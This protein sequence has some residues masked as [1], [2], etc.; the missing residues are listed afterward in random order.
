MTKEERL[1]AI[2]A[3]RPSGPGDAASEKQVRDAMRKAFACAGT[4]QE[5]CC[6]DEDQ[7][8]HC[9]RYEGHQGMCMCE[10]HR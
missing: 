8:E 7:P 4:C 6:V 10:G 1:A 9:I 5:S 2:R 3:G